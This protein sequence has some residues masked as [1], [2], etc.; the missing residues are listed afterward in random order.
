MR[1]AGVVVGLVALLGCVV[2][3]DRG[4]DPGR[5]DATYPSQ[6]ASCAD[7]HRPEGGT[8]IEANG[9]YAVTVGGTRLALA[10][11]SQDTCTT[12]FRI[13]PDATSTE[14]VEVRRGESFDVGDA[15]AMVINAYRTTDGDPDTGG[16]VAV[17]WVD[18]LDARVDDGS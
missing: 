7:P 13:G 8:T 1:R 6:S 10:S 2:A 15:H 3:C 5:A 12:S 9:R 14:L 17:L 18:D 4:T 16:T 11:V